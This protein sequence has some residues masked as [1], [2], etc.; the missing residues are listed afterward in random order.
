MRYGSCFEYIS[1]Y[2]LTLVVYCNITVLLIKLKKQKTSGPYVS[3]KLWVIQLCRLVTVNCSASAAVSSN[4]L[5][6][7]VIQ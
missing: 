4:T 1:I 7:A 2:L 3:M 5:L 6:L